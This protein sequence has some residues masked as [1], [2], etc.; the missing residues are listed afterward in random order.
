[1]PDTS[2]K[3]SLWDLREIADACYQISFA[4]YEVTKR[5]CY[6]II[7]YFGIDKVKFQV[8]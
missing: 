3:V 1:M 5:N 6:Q 7:R 4:G 8:I 2:P